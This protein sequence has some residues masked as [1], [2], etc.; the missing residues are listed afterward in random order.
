MTY[1][2][3]IGRLALLKVELVKTNIPSRQWYVM[4]ALNNGGDN[5][6]LHLTLEEEFA[7]V[8]RMHIPDDLA[9]RILEAARDIK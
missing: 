2:D 7:L 8:G 6:Y 3:L 1:N 4:Y 9:M 5:M